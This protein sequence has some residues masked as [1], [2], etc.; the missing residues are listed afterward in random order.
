MGFMYI[1][2]RHD[3]PM[4][5][6]AV[7]VAAVKELE[8]ADL[9]VCDRL[10]SSEVRILAFSIHPKPEKHRRTEFIKRSCSYVLHMSQIANMKDK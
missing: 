5:V 8:R 9:V 10:V 6:C 1:Y 2:Q 3:Y 4:H 7:T